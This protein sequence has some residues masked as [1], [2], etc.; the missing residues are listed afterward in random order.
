[1]A[2]KNKIYCVYLDNNEYTYSEATLYQQDAFKIADEFFKNPINIKKEFKYDK[3]GYKFGLKYHYYAY[4]M[5]RE[6]SNTTRYN[7]YLA[8]GKENRDIIL[9]K[10]EHPPKKHKSELSKYPCPI[11]STE[12]LF[13]QRYPL[14]VCNYCAQKTATINN[15]PIS[16]YNTSAFGGFEGINEK[17]QQKT[18]ESLC[19]ID[20]HKC[21]A[22]EA[23]FG[24]IVVQLIK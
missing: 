14:A 23:R 22:Q 6:Y 24:G 10:I 20:G 7:Q 18:T 13:S 4:E 5:I 21:Y 9:S 3:N 19:Y 17:T 11:C 2:D 8:M 12:T 16:Y 15:D 1:M